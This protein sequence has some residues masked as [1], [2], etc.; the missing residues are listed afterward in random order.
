MKHNYTP[1][2]DAFFRQCLS[3][4]LDNPAIER[5]KQVPQHKGGTTYGHCV[6]VANTA[7]RLAKQWRWAVD[8]RALVCGAMLHDYYLYDTETMPYSDYRHSLIHPKMALENAEKHFDIGVRER[9]IILSHMWP[10]PGAPLPCSREAWL[11]CIADKLCA[12]R[13]MR[14]R[15]K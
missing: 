14:R 10:I 12:Y 11:I 4:L 6:N 3:E 8:I 5:L 9:N 13:E 2:D 15:K 1:E 7:Y